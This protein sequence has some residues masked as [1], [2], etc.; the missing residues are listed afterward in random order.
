MAVHIPSNN[1]HEMATQTIP[2]KAP[3]KGI[4]KNS[5]A[6]P[7]AILD[8]RKEK[9]QYTVE[10]PMIPLI[11]VCEDAPGIGI[12]AVARR[13]ISDLPADIQRA[14][15]STVSLRHQFSNYVS[16][17]FVFAQP[18]SE[19]NN[20]Q[21]TNKLQW[22]GNDDTDSD[23]DSGSDYDSDNNEIFDTQPTR[24]NSSGFSTP[25]TEQNSPI[26]CPENIQV[27]QPKRNVQ[28][29]DTV[30]FNEKASSKTING[31][32]NKLNHLKAVSLPLNIE[33]FPACL[34]REIDILLAD[35]LPETELEDLFVTIDVEDE[36][37]FWR[38]KR[39]CDREIKLQR[40]ASTSMG[41]FNDE[42]DDE[43]EEDMTWVD[44]DSDH[45]S[46]EG[47]NDRMATR[48]EV[49]EEDDFGIVFGD[50]DE[51]EEIPFDQSAEAHSITKID[52]VI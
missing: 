3:L 42:D 22:Y 37:T 6:T 25:P 24:K 52:C 28:W 20:K 2:A 49:D 31:E 1:P 18:L 11:L 51:E 21:I 45:E 15:P 17:F 7:P 12:L 27:E 38:K 34:R 4:L 41:S 23:S 14:L 40:L 10:L 33:D 8:L 19:N 29:N 9:E 32:F 13:P 39:R 44:L 36:N 5:K 30:S 47:F 26:V 48:Y 35:S 46:E 43:E 16:S 50:D